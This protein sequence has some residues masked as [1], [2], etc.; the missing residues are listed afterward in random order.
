MKKEKF[1]VT[2]DSKSWY[3]CEG[4]PLFETS[5][6]GQRVVSYNIVQGRAGRGVIVAAAALNGLVGNIYYRETMW[7]TFNLS[8]AAT[9]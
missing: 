6:F 8:S 7:V 3:L 2:V 9:I 4:S 1:K 5:V